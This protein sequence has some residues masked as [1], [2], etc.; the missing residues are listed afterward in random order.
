M[1]LDFYIP[2][3]LAKNNERT[4]VKGFGLP[5][6]QR[7]IISAKNFDITTDK[8]ESISRF[9]TPTYGGLFVERPAYDV[10]SFNENTKEYVKEDMGS[11]L[12]E[13]TEGGFYL[14]N[15]IIDVTQ[16]KNIITTEVTDF[17]GTVK[18]YIADGDYNITIRT[19]IASLDP[20][21]YPEDQVQI[22]TSYLQAPRELAVTN[23][24]LNNIFKISNIVVTSFEMSQQQGLRNV[25]YFTINALSWYNYQLVEANV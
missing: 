16:S 2:K 20:D 4:L 1:A 21:N 18:E 10:Y 23:N 9:G 19:F 7:A 11:K 22:F 17:T 12:S 14:E 25:Q 15:C 13:N 24:F 3:P 5:L 6:V 8:S